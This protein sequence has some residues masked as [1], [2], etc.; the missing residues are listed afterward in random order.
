MK[1]KY[2]FTFNI[3]GPRDNEGLAMYGV[4][5]NSLPLMHKWEH[6]KI[7]ALNEEDCL[8]MLLKAMRRYI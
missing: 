6:V 8:N 7:R 1:N 3:L 4:Y 5:Q 2:G